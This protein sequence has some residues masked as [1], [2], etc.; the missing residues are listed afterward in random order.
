MFSVAA[1]MGALG[2]LAADSAGSKGAAV[3]FSDTPGRTGSGFLT[4]SGCEGRALGDGFEAEGALSF[5][6]G[7]A[8]FAVS[9]FGLAFLT[10]CLASGAF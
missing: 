1:P 8:G 10:S 6:G 5:A 7:S 4:E 3:F 9:G 2:A